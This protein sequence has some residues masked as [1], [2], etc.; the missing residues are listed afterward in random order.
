MSQQLELISQPNSF[1]V[2]YLLV[3][4]PSLSIISSLGVYIIIGPQ[5]QM[6]NFELDGS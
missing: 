5:M 3:T 1:L 2:S 6:Q 4:L